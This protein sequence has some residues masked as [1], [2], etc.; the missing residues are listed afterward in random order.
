MK[1]L[2]K[3]S[4]TVC[5]LVSTCLI[6]LTGCKGAGSKKVATEVLEIIGKKGGSKAASK[7]A[8]AIEREAAQAERAAA[9]EAEAYRPS[10]TTSRPRY[11]HS[12]DDDDE[13]D[14]Q[15]DYEYASEPEP[16]IYTLPCSQCGGVGFNYITD[17]YGNFQ[18]DYYG[19]P[20]I[21]QCSYCGGSGV[22]LVSQ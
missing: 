19:N 3:L 5:I 12:S 7:A 20:L 4:L 2:F 21:Q 17:Y 1:K 18:Y 8:S 13:Y 9:R 6:S 16:E 11:H 10:K 15:Y 22:M 14:Y